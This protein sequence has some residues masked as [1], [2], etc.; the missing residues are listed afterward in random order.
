MNEIY[1]THACNKVMEFVNWFLPSHLREPS[2]CS[3]AADML[4]AQPHKLLPN[5]CNILFLTCMLYD[6]V[7]KLNPTFPFCIDADKRPLKEEDNCDE[8]NLLCHES[9]LSSLSSP[10]MSHTPPTPSS[11]PSSLSEIE[12]GFCD[13]AIKEQFNNEVYTMYFIACFWISMKL[14]SNDLLHD[15]GFDAA[16]ML[17]RY[18]EC[19][20]SD[21]QLTIALTTMEMHIL[22]LCTFNLHYIDN[23]TRIPL[24]A[25]SSVE[26]FKL[27][28]FRCA[29]RWCYEQDDMNTIM[30]QMS[31]EY[32]N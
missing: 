17:C 24:R 3:D 26:T 15:I 22:E 2:Q 14:E 32:Y 1:K 7:I 30:E 12:S 25:S 20:S 13:E 8:V 27:F 28:T 11:L 19:T 5:A 9:P 29:L 21:E 10:A 4:Y 18:F 6:R 16:H 31:K 23:T